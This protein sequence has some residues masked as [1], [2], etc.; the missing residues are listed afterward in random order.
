MLRWVSKAFRVTLFALAVGVLLWLPASFFFRAGLTTPWP[1]G[2]MIA[3]SSGGVAFASS[4]PA[5][6]S[7]GLGFG[8]RLSW[9]DVSGG[10]QFWLET[11][12][13]DFGSFVSIPLWLLA[14]LCLAWPVTSFLL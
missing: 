9:E 13:E 1:S 8:R 12:T 4:W 6:M 14:F 5:P 10:N 7:F 11:Q 3:G 2:G